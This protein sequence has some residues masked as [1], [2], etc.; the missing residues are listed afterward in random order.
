MA[1]ESDEGLAQ[2]LAEAIVLEQY[3]SRWPQE[4]AEEEQRLLVALPNRFIAIEHFGSTAIAGLVA[5][6]VIDILA[7]LASLDE[8]D[9]LI[10]PLGSLGYHYPADFNSTLSDRKWLMRQ[11]R[12]RRTHHLHLVVFGGKVWSR[13][14]HFRDVLRTDPAIAE[15]YARRKAALAVT[16]RSD[17]EAYTRV[18]G[19]FIEAIL[20]SAV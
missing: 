16:Y 6:P 3:D 8:V 9:S 20:G 11:Q 12:G 14:L 19:E 7:G 2:A 4:F 15:E 1:T 13:E 10:D 18:K 17:R 5:K